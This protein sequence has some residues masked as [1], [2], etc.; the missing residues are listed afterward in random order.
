MVNK[1]EESEIGTGEETRLELAISNYLGTGIHLFLSLLAVLLLV[2][3]A[4]ATFDTV[5]RDFPKLWVE[6]QDEYGVLLK[7]IDNLLLIAITAEFG[8][9]LLFRRLSAA[10]EVVIFV[11]ARKT[12][13]PDITAFD[14]TLCAAAI[15]G[16]IAIRFY[17]L[18]GKTT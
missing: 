13:N 1:P 16:L 14:L 15:A 7:I 10:V 6:Q 17:Y 4:I 3:A 8:L 9:L 11:L 2:A 18:P 12:V 5:V